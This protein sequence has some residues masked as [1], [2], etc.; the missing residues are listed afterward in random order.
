MKKTHLLI[1][2][3]CFGFFPARAQDTVTLPKSQLIEL[4]KKAARADKLAIDLEK[5]QREISRLKGEI[6]AP[7]KFFSTPILPPQVEQSLQKLPP[8][9]PLA[10]LPPLTKGE[11][12]LASDLLHHYAMD[13]AAAN[14]RYRK[15]S[16]KLKGIITDLDKPLLMSPYRVIFRVPA[17]PLKIICDVR[18]PEQFKKVYVSPDRERVVGETY[19]GR[20]TLAKVGE[21][22][23]VQGRCAGLKDGVVAFDYSEKLSGQ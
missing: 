21:E 4:E 3:L 19:S 12:V 13:P 17:S 1:L 22:I 8:T 7:S 20:A 15:K 6:A 2:L 10:E 18:S 5:A 16:L 14:Q 11:V 23:I 9:R